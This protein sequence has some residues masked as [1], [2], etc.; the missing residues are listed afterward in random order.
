MSN[1]QRI[2][3]PTVTPRGVALASRALFAYLGALLGPLMAQNIFGPHLSA[4]AILLSAGAGAVGGGLV[5][6]LVT[7]PARSRMTAAAVVLLAAIATGLVAGVACGV[8]WISVLD[9]HPGMRD[10]VTVGALFGAI[11]GVVTGASFA[12]PFAVWTSRARAA[13]EAPSAMSAQRLAMDAGVMLSAGG[14][15]AVLRYR[16]DA[17]LAL[18]VG[19][20]FAG[21]VVVLAALVRTVRLGRL[22]EAVTRGA[23]SLAPRGDHTVAPV[24]VDATPLDHV[25]VTPVEATGGAAPFRANEHVRELALVPGDMAAVRR[26]V[27]ATVAY[28]IVTLALAAVFDASLAARAMSCC[29]GCQSAASSPCGHGCD[30]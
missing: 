29:G 14:A 23:L 13:L 3:V 12:A 9:P 8:A 10:G 11:F 28:G 15:L 7:R 2:P 20:C 1:E 30:P 22:H 25:I 27:G 4:A 26:A 17:L 18:G 19:T 16:H 24:L 21:T 6:R 5:G